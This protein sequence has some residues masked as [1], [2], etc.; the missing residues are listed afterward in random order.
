MPLTKE[1][2]NIWGFGKDGKHD[3]TDL[4]KEKPEYY[5]KLMRK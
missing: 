3:F 4:K 1:L 2:S 5:K